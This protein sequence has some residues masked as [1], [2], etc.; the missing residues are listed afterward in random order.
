MKRILVL[1]AAGLA[2]VT[3]VQ[4]SSAA[5][6]ASAQNANASFATAADWVAPA[7][8][9]G[10]PANGARTTDDTPALSGAAGNAT[11]DATTVSVKIYSGSSA[12][13]SAVQTLTPTRSAAA[14]SATA[15]TLADGTYTI[16]ATQADSAGNTGTSAANTFVVDTTRP[17]AAAVAATNKAGGTAGKMESG[18]LLTFTYS[19]AIDP[20][21][22]L[23]GW[24]GASMAVNVRVTDSALND[25]VTVLTTANVASISLGSVATGG[26]YVSGTTTFAST[27]ARS[28]DGKSV[29]VTFGA[30]SSVKTSA[31]SAK[32]M[33]WTFGIGVKDL[34]GNTIVTLPA[35]RAETDADVDF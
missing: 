26:D 5:F 24:S 16:Q 4:A 31:V 7:V 11:G 13:G 3:A 21:S 8:T 14:W 9:V 28:A 17:A 12:S 20:A 22:V 15:T 25:S 1:L 33:T 18:D 2:T 27:M 10:A 29:V 6:T 30:P 35:T 32:N 23:T 19:E 34:A